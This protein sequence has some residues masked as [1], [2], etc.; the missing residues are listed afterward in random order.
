MMRFSLTGEMENDPEGEF[1]FF[2]IES[3][4]SGRKGSKEDCIAVSLTSDEVFVMTEDLLTEE[5][6]SRRIILSDEEIKAIIKAWKG[7]NAS[8][9]KKEEYCQREGRVLRGSLLSV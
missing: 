7:N 2:R 4:A 3:F 5:L 9:K 6:N 1:K 8:E